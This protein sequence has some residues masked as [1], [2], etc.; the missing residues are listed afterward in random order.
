MVIVLKS[1]SWNFKA[2]TFE[3]LETVNFVSVNERL[4]SKL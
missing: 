4:E 1:N 2:L 3:K